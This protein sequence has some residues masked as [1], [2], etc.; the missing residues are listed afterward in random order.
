L[1]CT[2]KRMYFEMVKNSGPVIISLSS[3]DLLL[4]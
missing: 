3:T 1:S 2:K 4:H